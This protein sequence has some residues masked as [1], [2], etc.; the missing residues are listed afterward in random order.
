MAP[1]KHLEEGELS[2]ERKEEL[3]QMLIDHGLE[4]QSLHM[5]EFE[6]LDRALKGGWTLPKNTELVDMRDEYKKEHGKAT[7]K[8]L[9]TFAIHAAREFLGEPVK[10]KGHHKEHA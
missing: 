5:R 6:F 4:I 7:P 10:E 9:S 8:H 3:Q 1:K 2:Q